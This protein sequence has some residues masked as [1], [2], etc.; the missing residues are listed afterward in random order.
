[1]SEKE[2]D[3]F[4]L[5]FDAQSVVI[6]INQMAKIAHE[7]EHGLMTE[8]YPIFFEGILMD[9]DINYYY[10]GNGIEINE[11]VKISSIVHIKV[12]EDKDIYETILD[13]MPDP[14]NNE[15]VN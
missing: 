4:F 12:N 6:T 1:M 15:D 10:L 7:T 13:E 8:S 2:L 9:R 3:T 11:A 5:T 14:M